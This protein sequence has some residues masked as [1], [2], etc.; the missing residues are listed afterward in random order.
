VI[1]AGVGRVVCGIEDPDPRVGGKGLDK[2]RDAGVEIVSGVLEAECRDLH[3][4]HIRRVTQ[5]RPQVVLKLAMTADGFAASTNKAPLSITGTIANAQTQLM[6]A[7]SDAIMVGVGTVLADDPM[8]T[9]RLPG[10]EARSPI[11]VVLDS[12]LRTPMSAALVKSARVTPTWVIA[13]E[14]A[15]QHAQARL[16][17]QGVTIIRVG[18]NELG[19]VNIS[20]AAQALG[21]RGVTSLMCEGGP[22]LAEELAKSDLIDEFVLITSSRKLGRPG[23]AALGATLSKT[24]SRNF[25]VAGEP[26]I[27]GEDRFIRYLKARPCS[28]AL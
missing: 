22:A 7:R 23:L 6:R 9:C 24:L 28:P 11:R 1:A 20:Q 27:F 25:A 3:A 12:H 8:L 13:R 15:S 5:G 18:G 17:A 26:L 10:L 19:R 21:A 14:D 4:G 16:E 2:L